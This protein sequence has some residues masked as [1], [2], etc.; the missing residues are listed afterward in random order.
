MKTWRGLH[1]PDSEAHLMTWMESMNQERGGL[2]CYQLHKYDAALTYC[3][4]RRVAL[5]VGANVGLWSRVMAMDF[6][7]VIAF[8]PVQQYADCWRKNVTGAE[9]HVMAL[10]ETAGTVQMM[11]AT[12]D[13][14]GD[15]RPAGVGRESGELVAAD[16]E[17]RTLDSFEL[18]QVDFLKCDNEG[19][20]L[21]VMR[22]GTDTLKRCR[23]VVCVEQKPGH[24]KTF[25]LSDTA[26]VDYLKTLGM[27]VREV[28]SGDYILTWS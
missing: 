1:F 20:E 28:I 27:K 2:P 10:G 18:D 15:T 26:A 6:Q 5:D 9:L 17:M 16:V 22:G 21:F 19:Y 4:K 7:K 14:C 13:S 24:G 12:P 23:P 25:G 8:E 3:S 11:K